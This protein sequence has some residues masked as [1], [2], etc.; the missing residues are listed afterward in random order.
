MIIEE[1]VS[2]CS[3]GNIVFSEDITE[4]KEAFERNL[5]VPNTQLKAR[6][7]HEILTYIKEKWKDDEHKLQVFIAYEGET[8][9]GM[10]MCHIHPQ[11]RSYS[12][13]CGTFGW[14]HADS[15]ETCKQ[16]VHACETYIKSHKLRK[17]R[18]NI[19]QPKCLGGIGIQFEGFGEQMMYGVAFGDPHSRVLEYLD[20]LG[21]IRE[22]EYT[23]MKV[24]Q[25]TWNAGKKIDPQIRLGYLPLRELRERKEEILNLAQGSF[26]TVLPDAVGGG[27]RFEEVMN[28]YTQVPDSHYAL[29]ED[30]NFKAYCDIPE[31]I[32]AWQTCDLEHVVTWAPMAFDRSTGELVGIILS[33]PDLYEVWLGKPI[34][35][36]NVDTVMVK[37]EYTG[38]GIFSAL[39]NI[40]QLTCNL[41]GIHYYEGTTI[42][43]N[44]RDAIKAIFPHGTPIRRHYVVQKRI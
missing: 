34:T 7:I 24:T 28:M 41:N 22:S 15:F 21:Y 9:C 26:Y 43:S 6:I 37:K 4:I 5:Y 44:N 29:S 30:I 27:E 14:L 12:R 3:K 13:K 10:V 42:W 39:N 32:E 23:C 40:G 18:G 38:K 31:F 36:N 17:L 19:N 1:Q 33:L 35:R 25:Q 8:I 2:N 11:Y 16:L 20:R